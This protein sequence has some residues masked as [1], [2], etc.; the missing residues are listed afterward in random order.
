[1]VWALCLGARLIIEAFLGG[2]IFTYVVVPLLIFLARII[3]V[4]LGTLRVIYISKGYKLIAPALGFFEVIV[5]LLA[6]S[7]VMANLTNAFCYIAYGAG[8][9]AGTYV[10]MRLEEKVLIGKVSMRVVTRREANELI[11]ELRDAGHKPTVMEAEG[12]KG[13]S[14]VMF[15]VLNRAEI[16]KIIGLVNQFDPHAFCTVEDI[17]FAYDADA[18]VPPTRQKR[19]YLKRFGFY[20][21]GK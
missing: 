12:S 11:D 14:K 20:R 18:L 1:M 6:I 5:W 3:D 9:A 2:E 15:M 13:P 7:H 21:K 19:K 16:P 17:K 4:S 8:F 10:G